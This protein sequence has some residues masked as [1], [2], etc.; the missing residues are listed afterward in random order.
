MTSSWFFLSTLNYD[1]RSATHQIQKCAINHVENVRTLL[2][3][4]DKSNFSITMAEINYKMLTEHPF[5]AN[6]KVKRW[7][8]KTS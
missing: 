1:A 4:D 5:F 6:T 8:A 2:N 7:K 3:K